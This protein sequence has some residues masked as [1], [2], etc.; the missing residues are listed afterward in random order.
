MKYA[1]R[2]LKYLLFICVLYVALMWLSSISTYGGAVDTMTLLRAQLASDRGVWLVVAFVA[3]ALFYPKF[4]YVRRVIEGADM[5]ADR[6]RIDNAMQLYGF[7]FAEV[8]D[9]GLVYR[10]EGVVRRIILL[11][12]DEIIVRR[13]EGGIEVEGKRRQAVRIIFQLSAYIDNKRFE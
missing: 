1:V 8:R 2:S 12:E 11:F 9:G 13:V 6:V 5:D 7:K 10:A 4:G 3:L